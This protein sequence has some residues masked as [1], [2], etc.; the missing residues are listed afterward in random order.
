MNEPKYCLVSKE[1]LEKVIGDIRQSTTEIENLWRMASD[2]QRPE[3]DLL[4][5]ELVQQE[6]YEV[7]ARME[8]NMQRAE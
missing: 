1:S 4:I 6:L 5:L 2:Q 3:G 7:L 8:K